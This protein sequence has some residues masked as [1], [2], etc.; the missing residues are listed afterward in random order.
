MTRDK[1]RFLSGAPFRK[2]R[3][4]RL[5]IA[6]TFACNVYTASAQTSVIIYPAGGQSMEQ[7]ASDEN[8]CRIWA[9]GQTGFNPAQ[10]ANIPAGAQTGGEIVGGAVRGTAVGA[11][12]GLIG[13]DVG[14]GAA[15]GA[16]AGATAGLMRKS[17]KK[18]ANA[19]AQ[20]Q[21]VADY[22][23]RLGEYNR[24]FAACMQGRGYSVN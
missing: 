8:E 23:A 7:Q 9:Q 15:I 17:R 20:Q 2:Y 16:G 19:Q 1:D 22:N 21:A 3:A 4:L 11:V 5:L 12:G 6:A 24:A 10:G 13:G 14:K 18:Q